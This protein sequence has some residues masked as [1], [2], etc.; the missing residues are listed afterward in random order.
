[1]N[2]SFFLDRGSRWHALYPLTKLTLALALIVT[3]FSVRWTFISIALFVLVIVPIAFYGKIWREVLRT[4]VTVILPL[5]ISLSL[6]QGFFYPGAHDV[7]F[8]IGPLAL[9]RE[10]LVFAFETGTRLLLIAGAGLVVVYA[11]H[12]ADLALAMVQGGA[13]YALAYIVVTAIQLLPEMQANA[14][15]I[16][17]AQQARGLET[18]GSLRVRLGAFLPLIAPLVYGALEN[19]QERALALDARAF[20]ASRTKTSWRELRDTPLQRAARTGLIVY[21]VGLLIYAVISPLVLR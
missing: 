4:T 10:G 21:M 11:T 5:A 7:L 12:P 3:A 2:Q 17:N 16:L 8:Q 13:P 14:Q 9:K 19:V 6:V 20:R 1:M 15:G 18:T